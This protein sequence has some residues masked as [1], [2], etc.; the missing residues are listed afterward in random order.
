MTQ[1]KTYTE[2]DIKKWANTTV[3]LR[4]EGII[5]VKHYLDNLYH[6]FVPNKAGLYVYAMNSVKPYYETEKKDV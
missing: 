3:L 1:N 5:M 2:E 6:Y 4:Q